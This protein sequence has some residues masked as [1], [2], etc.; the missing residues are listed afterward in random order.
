MK[1]ILLLIAFIQPL[2]TIAQD[3]HKISPLEKLQMPAYLQRINS[4]TFTGITLPPSSPVRASAEWE[5]IDALMITWTSFPAI[6]TQIVQAA[7]NET[8]VI[9]VCSDSNAVKNSLTGSGVSLSNIDYLVAPFDRIWARDYGQWNIYTND[10][11]SLALVDWIYNRPRYND[12]SV[13]VAI[14]NYTGLPLYRTL[15]SPFDLIHTGGNFMCDGFG[16]GFS[17]KLILN[18]N[19]TKTEA[20]VDTIMKKFMGINRYIKMETL[21]YDDIHHIDMHIKLLD[22][23]TLLVGEYPAG[24]ADGPQIEANL[25]YVLSNF[26]SVYGTP[27]KV[28]RIPMPPDAANRYPNQSGDYRTYAN[29]VFVNKTVI[30]PVYDPQYDSTALRIYREALPGYNVV[31]VNCNSIITQLGAIHCITK[32]VAASD[33]LLISHQALHDTYNTSSPYDVIARIQHR[34]GIQQAMIYYRTDTTLQWQS[35]P[36]SPLTSITHEGQIPPQP[37]GTTVYYYIDAQ[38]VSG[39]TQ[40][41][42]LTAPAG[43]WKFNVLLNTGI[44]NSDKPILIENVFPNPSK[45]M[46]CIPVYTPSNSQISLSLRNI[47]NEEVM[48]IYNGMNTG[49]KKYFINTSDISSGVYILQLKT[50]TGIFS[51]K[52]IIR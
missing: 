32:E 31:G 35:V 16:T 15:S 42:P 50:E 34:S 22:E 52:L 41:R 25:Q 33:P 13:P 37:A 26:N 12:D 38:S 23:E 7:Q 46:T 18:E 17:S 6:L 3:D 39:K 48:L 27:Y 8:K 10:V 40:V 21:P 44:S 49:D 51:Q 47:L 36:M 2:S 28:I 20:Q 45:G 9:I 29:S 43:Y 24:I 1:R 5:E 14:H 19:P 4:N 30:L 11:D